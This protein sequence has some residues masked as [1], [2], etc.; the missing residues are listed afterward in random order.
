MAIMVVVVMVAFAV[1]V[2]AR[3]MQWALNMLGL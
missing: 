2:V 3:S 1:V